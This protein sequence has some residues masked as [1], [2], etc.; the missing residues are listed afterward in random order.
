R[1]GGA[2][3]KTRDKLEVQAKGLTRTKTHNFIKR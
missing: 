1:T 3:T 2:E